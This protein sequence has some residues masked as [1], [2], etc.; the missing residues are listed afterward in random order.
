[1]NFLVFSVALAVLN[2]GAVYFIFIFF[3][4][5]FREALD[6][7][8]AVDEARREMGALIAELNRTTERNVTLIEDRIASI[9]EAIEEADRRFAL[10]KREA[11]GRDRERTMIDRLARAKP[12]ARQN[13]REA[14]SAGSASGA[15][16][17]P[18]V[19]ESSPE[20]AVPMPAAGIEESGT[21]PVA[22]P[23]KENADILPGI[24][25]SAQSIGLEPDPAERA[26]SLWES[27]LSVSLIATRLSMT[28]AEVDLIIAMEEQRRLTAT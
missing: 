13:A 1:M 7:G 2:L 14:Y 17:A 4:K 24:F 8:K 3:R 27:G 12:L 28:V 21:A 15:K 25:T 11:E 6:V 18:R 10:L 9:G 23:A 5:R 20:K 19:Q 22:V 16:E 26:V